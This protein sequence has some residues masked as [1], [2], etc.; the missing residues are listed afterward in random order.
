MIGA[1][2]VLFWVRCIYVWRIRVDTLDAAAVRG[3][4]LKVSQGF[5]SRWGQLAH[6]AKLQSVIRKRNRQK[7]NIDK[8]NHQQETVGE[9]SPC[10]GIT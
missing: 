9:L 1:V 7:G 4:R 2:R 5:Y 6:L 3:A 8:Q 10:L